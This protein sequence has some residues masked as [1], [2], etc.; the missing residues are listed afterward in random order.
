MAGYSGTPLVRKLGIKSGHAVAAIH[1][2]PLFADTLGELPDHATLQHGMTPGADVYV[3]FYDA[4]ASLITDLPKL[5]SAIYPDKTL[6]IAWPKKASK[7]A[8]D[9]DGNIV[10]ADILATHMVDVKVCAIDDT[11][12]ALKAMWRREH[13]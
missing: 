7:R 10:R 4:H 5:E 13:R 3:A 2:P 9:L 6:W 1:A 8:T 12:S 11:W